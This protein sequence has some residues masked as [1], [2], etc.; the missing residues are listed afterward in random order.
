MKL[1]SWLQTH[2][3]TY[4][5]FAARV[6]A[7]AHAVQKWALGLRMPRPGAVRAID[8][9]TSGEVSAADWY[10]RERPSERAARAMDD[11]A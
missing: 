2:N 7:S 6:G 9:A 11:V 4:A 3:L 10:A 8:A 1:S 5:A